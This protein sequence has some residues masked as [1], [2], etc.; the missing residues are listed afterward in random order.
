[1]RSVKSE[2]AASSDGSGLGSALPST[3]N[4]PGL[5]NQ[6]LGTLKYAK[7]VVFIVRKS[8]SLFQRVRRGVR[9]GV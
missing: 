1:M 6:G 3:I 5:I 4:I 7:P 2:P 8:K 9:V